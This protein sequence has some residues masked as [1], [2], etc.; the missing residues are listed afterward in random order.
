LT[1]EETLNL[2]VTLCESCVLK[3]KA[4]NESYSLDY[5]LLD[6]DPIQSGRYIPALLRILLPRCCDGY[7]CLEMY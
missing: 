1:G 3:I 2:H 4:E 5:N 7:L 6:Y